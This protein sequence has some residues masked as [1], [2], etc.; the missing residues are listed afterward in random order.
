MV[1]FKGF[2]FLLVLLLLKSFLMSTDSDNNSWYNFRK[3]KDITY[4]EIIFETTK[5]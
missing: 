1:S 4:S 5:S 2:Y 3:L